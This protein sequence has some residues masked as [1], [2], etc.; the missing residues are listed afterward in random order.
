M[1][2]YIVRKLPT[3]ELCGSNLTATQAALVVLNHAVASYDIRR[4]EEGSFYWLWI[5]TNLGT[6][7]IARNQG[8]PI[9][10]RAETRQIAWLTIASQVLEAEWPGLGVWAATRS[11]LRVVQD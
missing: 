4:A 8:R 5:E 3:G 2:G 7:E 6:M 1:N 11:S 9:G 10:A